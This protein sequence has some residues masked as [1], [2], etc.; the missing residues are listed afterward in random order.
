VTMR[1]SQGSTLREARFQDPS[2]LGFYSSGQRYLELP[3]PASRKETTTDTKQ[4]Q[5]DTLSTCRFLGATGRNIDV[6]IIP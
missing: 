1:V 6:A 5:G 2:A 4:D 3:Q